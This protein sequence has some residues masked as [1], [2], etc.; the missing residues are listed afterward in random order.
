[1]LSWCSQQSWWRVEANSQET[2][3]TPRRKN[4]F[5]NAQSVR[6]TNRK[7]KPNYGLT[8]VEIKTASLARNWSSSTT[9]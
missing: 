6:V 5:E 2:P 1:M 9:L 3:F 7:K 8:Q 4:S